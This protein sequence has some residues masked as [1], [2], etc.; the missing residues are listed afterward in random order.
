MASDGGIFTYGDAGFY[1]SH[2]GSHLNQPIV[3]MTS[4]PDGKGYWLVASDGGI[5]TYG[6]AGFYGSHGGSHLNQPIVG[7]TSTPAGT[8]TG[9]WP[10]T[11]ASSP[12]G[13]HRSTAAWGVPGSPTPSV[14]LPA[15]FPPDPR[16]HPEL[17]T[18]SSRVRGSVRST[19]R[20]SP[21][22]NRGRALGRELGVQSAS[23]PRGA[24]VH[25]S[26]ASPDVRSLHHTCLGACA[27][28]GCCGQLFTR[29][30]WW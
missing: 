13:T 30:A 11:V 27:A 29:R 28:D 7:M 15:R 21:N 3:G 20:E 22:A 8:V 24:S 6:D 18:P 9:W 23:A 26:R 10:P 5:F 17:S 12:T 4:T 2:G 1:G 19:A 25:P 16:Y 14:S